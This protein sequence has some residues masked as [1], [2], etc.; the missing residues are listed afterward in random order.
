MAEA[1]RLVEL[2]GWSPYFCMQEIY[3]G[4]KT[5]HFHKSVDYRSFKFH[6]QFNFICSILLI[7]CR[8][9]M[10][11]ILYLEEDT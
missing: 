10:L 8:I 3:P 1:R 9:R 7:G 5:S 2:F 4:D 11:S 6:L